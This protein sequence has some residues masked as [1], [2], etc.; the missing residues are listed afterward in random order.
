MARPRS[1][2]PR[3]GHAASNTLF[4]DTSFWIGLLRER[5]QHGASALRWKAWTDER[6]TPLL[7]T[8]GVLW[9]LLNALARPETRGAAAAVY[10]Q[11]HNGDRIELLAMRPSL[12]RRAFRLFE[13]RTDKGWSLTDC[14]SFIVMA[15]RGITRALTTDHHYQQAG[16]RAL[17]LEEPPT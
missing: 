15:Q 16:F 1:P 2:Q 10:R 8:E 17:M 7:T 11:C 5:D 14:V 4:V 12:L 3:N 13:S 9:E 6:E